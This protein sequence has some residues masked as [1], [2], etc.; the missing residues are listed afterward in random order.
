MPSST[1]LQS[2]FLFNTSYFVNW[3]AELREVGGCEEETRNGYSRGEKRLYIYT[4]SSG[5]SMSGEAT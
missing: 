1:M 4:E 5:L 2:Y 3:V